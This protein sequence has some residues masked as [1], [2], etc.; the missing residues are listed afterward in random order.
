MLSRV[1]DALFWMSRY[2][3]RAEHVAR[4][5]DVWFHLELDLSGA[6]AAPYEMHWT[7]LAAILQQQVPPLARDTPLPV[8]VSRWFSFDLDNPNSIMACLSRARLNARS[9]RGTINSEVWRELNKLHW[10]LNDAEFVRRARESPYE[11]YQSVQAGS[12]LFQGLCD[13]TSSHDEGWQFVQLGKLVER[14]EKTL[15]ILDIQYHLLRDL[16]NPDDV[17]LSTLHWAAVL[18][19]CGAFEPYQRLY[20]G[21][22]EPGRVV[23]FLLLRPDFPRSVRFC[24]EAFARALDGIEGP[25][26]RRSLTGA[27]R[28]LGRMLAE[29][30]YLDLDVVLAGDLHAFLGRLTEQC[31]QVSRAVQERY[32]LR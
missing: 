13:A 20:L 11:F 18:R 32:A 29:L 17:S 2:V 19:S 6:G 4:L 10:R 16:T 8:A 22:V 9:I 31:S 21:R 5:L 24:L 23:A 15:R 27:D 7:A 30:R 25:A 28:L 14:A 3:E 12:A 1:A 26:E